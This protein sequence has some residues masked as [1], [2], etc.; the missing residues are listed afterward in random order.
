MPRISQIPSKIENTLARLGFGD[1]NR[2][3]K[4]P[5]TLTIPDRLSSGILVIEL[6]TNDRD[7]VLRSQLLS[8]EEKLTFWGRTLIRAKKGVELR[9]LSA[10]FCPVNYYTRE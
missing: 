3:G 6:E 5:A 10:F 1:T 2:R 9:I 8:P 4:I 7:G